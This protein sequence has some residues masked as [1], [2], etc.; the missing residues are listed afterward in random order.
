MPIC[1]GILLMITHPTLAWEGRQKQQA[2]VV[3]HE[4]CGC[5]R[6]QNLWA[7]AIWCAPRSGMQPFQRP[8]RP[9]NQFPAGVRR[10]V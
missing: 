10:K 3:R 2:N 8:W 9:A 6:P 5:H 1:L 4:G 7:L